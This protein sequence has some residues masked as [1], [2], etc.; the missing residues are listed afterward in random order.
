MSKAN[1]LIVGSGFAGLTSAIFSKKA[2]LPLR[3]F[4]AS[5][6]PS[7]I[8]G[9]VTIFPNGMR[10]LRDIGI[11]EKVIEAG[12]KITAAVFNNENGIH[13][14]DRSMGTEDLYSEPTITIR[15]AILLQLLIEKAESLGVVIE[16]GK[17][18]SSVEN[19]LESI[20][21]KFEDNGEAEGQLLIGADG[22]NSQVRDYIHGKSITPNYS[23]LI[24]LAGFV[25]D[26]S[27]LSSLKLKKEIQ[28]V[29]VGPV[30]FFAY[31]YIDNVDTVNE[32]ALLWYCY[33]DQKKRL[34]RQE[35]NAM[36]DK[37][38]VEKVAKAHEGWH[39]PIQDLVKSTSSVCKASVSDI[40]GLEKWSKGRAIIIG[41]AAHGMNPISGQGAST[42]MED[43]ALLV[44]LIVEFGEDYNFILEKFEEVRRPRVT[45]IG[46]KARNSSKMTM[47]YFGAFMRWIRNSAFKVLTKLTPES[48]ANWSFIYDVRNDFDKIKKLR[49]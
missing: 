23:E 20:R 22:V 47:R 15:R 11:R 8:G 38:V 12:A 34:S 24:Y 25:T 48:L 14:V 33:L 32:P 45:K 19:G 9:S 46:A 21:I 40:V 31:S 4:E 6:G 43:S 39:S 29:T 28:Y 41:D 1:L 49:S 17:K 30:G 26:Q 37:E 7:N 18:L 2:G 44:R 5:Q 42:A 3:I 10:I 16:Y 13:M 27:M 36:T 35:L